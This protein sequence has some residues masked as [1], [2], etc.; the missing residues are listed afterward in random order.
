MQGNAYVEWLDDGFIL[1]RSEVK[2]TPK[3][4]SI[5]GRSEF[6]DSYEMLYYDERGISRVYEMILEGNKWTI[7]RRDPDFSQRFMAE[8]SKDY[9]AIHGVWEISKDGMSWEHDFDLTYQHA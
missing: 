9:K 6:K 2:G 7:I 4:T 1:M 3:S 8:I 5:I